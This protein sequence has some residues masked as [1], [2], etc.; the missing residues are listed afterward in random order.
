MRKEHQHIEWK[1]SWRDEYLKWL[2]GFANAEGG[3]LVIGRDDQGLAVGV[4]NAGKLLEDI[5][6]KVRDVLGIMVDVNLR[7]EDGKE[8]LEIVIAPYPNPISYRGEYFYRSGSTNQ[9]LKGAALDRFLLRK[10]GRTWDGAPLPGL[11]VADL[12]SGALKTFRR[13]ALKSQRLPE[14]VLAEPDQALLEKLHLVEG[15]YLTRAA[16]LMFHPEPERFF[17]GAYVKIGY[18]EGNVDLRYQDEVQGDLVSQVN[19]TIEVLRAK[20]LRAWITYEGLQRLETWPVP[21]PALREAVLNA[22]VHKDY[23]CGTPIQISVYPDKLMIWNPGELPPEWT[24]KKLLG[25]HASIPFNPDVANV[26]FRTGM[27]E[28]WGRGIERI[29]EACREASTPVPEVKCEPGG[30]WLVFAFAPEPVVKKLGAT[31]PI[32]T[33][34]KILALLKAQPTIT[35]NELATKIGISAEGVKYHLGKMSSAGTIRHVGP[36]K[37]GHWEVLK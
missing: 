26:F 28:S 32:T 22:V 4:K 9:M 14:A 31:N 12:D 8:T 18:F 1:E 19:Q 6:N 37:A 15:R 5:P 30:L 11:T 24:I 23:S 29:M 33:Q 3:M 34:E 10:H 17:T 16:A 36:T 20:Y 13:L 27:I 7:E 25:K 21:M 2:C 35:R